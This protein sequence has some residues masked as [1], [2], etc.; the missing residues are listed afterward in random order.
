MGFK[1]LC[2]TPNVKNVYVN[3][4]GTSNLDIFRLPTDT[5][6]EDS[7]ITSF[8]LHSIKV[9][10]LCVSANQLHFLNLR[11][12]IDANVAGVSVGAKVENF[13]DIHLVLAIALADLNWKGVQYAKQMSLSVD[14]PA[15][16]NFETMGVSLAQAR[17]AV[18]QFGL[19]LDGWVTTKDT[20]A[21]DI[22]LDLQD[23][24]YI[25]IQFC[26]FKDGSYKH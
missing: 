25:I 12:S 22:H 2:Q 4:L 9:D 5:A 8:P 14:I 20:I 21:M 15:H 1:V 18:N 17:V 6:M 10:R 19:T 26:R 11:D 13:Q 3:A 16:L 23:L 24:K 7:T